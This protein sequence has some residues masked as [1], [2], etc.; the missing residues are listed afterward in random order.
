MI[1]CRPGKSR[2]TTG[3]GFFLLS[4]SG[5]ASSWAAEAVLYREFSNRLAVSV[6]GGT[7]PISAPFDFDPVTE[8]FSQRMS[9]VAISGSDIW[10]VTYDT[11]GSA[12]TTGPGRLWLGSLESQGFVPYAELPGPGEVVV[13][14]DT[15]HVASLDTAAREIVVRA[16]APDGVATPVF[17]MPTPS[18]STRSLAVGYD[19]VERELLIATSSFLSSGSQNV[20]AVSTASWEVV[21]SV[22]TPA[23]GGF[24][25]V[26][27]EIVVA[28]A[29]RRVNLLQS[30]FSFDLPAAN[31]LSLPALN[32][33]DEA[34]AGYLPRAFL[35][36][37]ETSDVF[38]FNYESSLPAV[39]DIEIR[40]TDPVPELLRVHPVTRSAEVLL[41]NWAT[42]DDT[43]VSGL[44]GETFFTDLPQGITVLSSPAGPGGL[45]QR[46]LGTFDIT[47]NP[48]QMSRGTYRLTPEPSLQ[49]DYEVEGLVTR[50]GLEVK[51]LFTRGT[52]LYN[53]DV[54]V[55]PFE[56]NYIGNGD[57]FFGSV[58]WS[59]NSDSSSRE[60]VTSSGDRSKVLRITQNTG[61]VE[62]AISQS[63]ELGV[64]SE[65][66]FFRME[67]RLDL[68]PGDVIDNLRVLV[69]GTH[70]GSSVESLLFQDVNLKSVGSADWRTA[71][72]QL[73][74]GHPQS[75]Q[76]WSDWEDIE[77]VVEFDDARGAGDALPLLIEFDNFYLGPTLGFAAGD[78][79]GDGFV[80][81]ADLDLVLLNWGGTAAPTE[82]LAFDQFNGFRIDQGELDSV[83]LNWGDGTQPA[84]SI[85]EPTVFAMLILGFWGLLLWQPRQ[86]HYPP[87]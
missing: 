68:E 29:D 50:R 21:R 22:D 69:R 47:I 40:T 85:P 72:R 26:I 30:S 59:F 13:V 15:P 46:S 53:F 52:D 71:S 19:T 25:A 28:P 51:K 35:F 63:L 12:P 82:W 24:G 75:G 86:K 6:A 83:L 41:D 18:V 8:D 9:S 45:E 87:R 5:S 11:S 78:L 74:D 49:A 27:S 80:S 54:V 10:V 73:P 84:I 55:D 48:T 56:G 76:P 66:A 39:A 79:N 7:G 77:L 32:V 16:V 67:Y 62:S 23:S 2:I 20:A 64:P 61:D 31:V 70:F 65:P 57:F 37:P 14:D 81:Q 42:P 4:L 60:Y 36:P 58:A 17:S 34:P 38:A 3:L 44:S 43:R 33:T 1:V